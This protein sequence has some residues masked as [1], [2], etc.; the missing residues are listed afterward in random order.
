MHKPH[1]DTAQAANKAS[2]LLEWHVVVLEPDTCVHLLYFLAMLFQLQLS[3][4]GLR[5]CQ[6][7]V[8]SASFSK[9]IVLPMIYRIAG[10]F[11]GH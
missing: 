4:T 11:G 8:V 1:I 7:W 9:W 5:D 6:E 10:K 3:G 2:T